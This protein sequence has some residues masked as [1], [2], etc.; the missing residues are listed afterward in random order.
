MRRSA[1]ASPLNVDIGEQ[2]RFGMAR[3]ELDDY[4]RVRK[5]HGGTVND[6][7]LA[8][9]AGALR[10]WLLTRGEPVT[11]TTTLRAMVPVSVRTEDQQGALG[12]R[13]SSYFVDLPVGEPNPVMRLHQVSYAMKAHKET[14][15]SV[16][17]DAIIA[18][19]GFAPPT[20][21]SAAAR[22]A[23]GFTKR[24]FNV[25]VTNV[26]GPQFPLY[27]AG[28][29]M[30]AAYPVVPLAKGQAVSIG[31]TSY[32]GGVYY[33]LNADRDAM[34]DVD[35]LASLIEDSLAELVDTGAMGPSMSDRAQPR[36]GLVLGAGGVLGAAWSIGALRALGRTRG[37]DPREAEVIIG[38]SAGSVVGAALGAGISVQTL[39]NHQRGIVEDGDPVIEYDA[40]VDTGGALPPRPKL[41]I[42]SRSLL[43]R[44]ARHPRRY[45]PLAALAALAPHGRGSLDAVGEM[46]TALTPD[47]EWSPHANLWVIA[48]DYD[49][50][51]RVAFGR[52][53]APRAR[54]SEAV[55]A[56]CAIPGWF[57]PVT[58]D[59]R[60]YVDGGT[61]SPTSLDLLAGRGLDEVFV[62][63]PMTSF[64]YD[65]PDSVVGRLERRFRRVV[66]RRLLREATKVRR[67]GT[68]VT[69][70]GPGREDLEAIGVNLMDPARRERVLDT[71]LRTSA[72]ALV[73]VDDGATAGL[74][75]AG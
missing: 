14:G 53:G 6:V 2:R 1:P 4:K 19:S 11:A 38:T 74:G 10:A 59:G 56:S 17:A 37:F 57:A 15:Q 30:L 62:L 7:V 69:L 18:L 68:R 16:G 52:A 13:V 8:T 39:V 32:D 46:I 71:S 67:T 35:V 27:A 9:V 66:T 5:A 43:L 55:M 31:L 70:L 24:L 47:V 41:G 75:V 36:R 60:R 20:I 48:M 45:P 3:T 25:V 58:I 44:A 64:S 12:N 73:A 65:E 61:W 33:G 29:R 49:T 72:A 23:S 63:S 26:P 51:R 40:E 28:A 50:G 22:L 34:P 21:H 42:G 54:L